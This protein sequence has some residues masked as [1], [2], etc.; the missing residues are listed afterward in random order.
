MTISKS[1]LLQA[2]REARNEIYDTVKLQLQTSTPHINR[3][4][5]QMTSA[6]PACRELPDAQ[7]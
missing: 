6:Q 5:R 4:L 3:L 7:E 1:R 2:V